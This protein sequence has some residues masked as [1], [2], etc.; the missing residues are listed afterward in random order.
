LFQSDAADDAAF[1]LWGEPPSPA[2]ALGLT[3]ARPRRHDR[4][5]SR[6]C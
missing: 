4:E 6:L 5:R 3:S 2:L 1:F